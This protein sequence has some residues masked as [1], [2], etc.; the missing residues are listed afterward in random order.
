MKTLR[1][2][3]A[4]AEKKEL[5]M[6]SVLIL[7]MA[8]SAI[9]NP[10]FL[11]VTNLLNILGQNAVVG[12]MALG[13]VFSLITG[14]FDMS[15]SST[16]ALTAVIAT[17]LFKSAGFIPGVLGGLLT[18]ATIGLV[19]GLLVTKA[20]INP[21][22][23]TLG[24]QTFGR[25]VV[26]I[27]TGAK[28]ITGIPAAYGVIGMGKIGSIPVPALIWAGFALIMWFVLSKT[29]F[30]QYVYAT[31]GNRRAAWLSGVNTDK[32]RIAAL[33][34]SGI[35]ASAG[36]IIYNLRVLMCTADALSGYELTVMAS[37]I[38]GGTSLEGG[39]GSVPGAIIGALIMGMLINILQI[40][41]VSSFWQA[42][43]TGVIIIGA[44]GVDSLT[45]RVKE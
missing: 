14:S 43:V 39:R 31:G 27:I 38:I 15:V 42:A 45:S 28:P 33:M 11:S 24:M 7:M 41:G 4:I 10:V 32:V 29:L 30:G 3:R 5:T 36:G 26:Y 6:L 34:L 17:H 44:V 20:R 8:V 37:C 2:L 18:G 22:V 12:V 16:A 23:T 13:M 19:N 21:F 1:T 35:F 9:I 40:T 25:G